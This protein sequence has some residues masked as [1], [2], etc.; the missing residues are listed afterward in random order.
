MSLCTLYVHV[1]I[2]LWSCK[3]LNSLVATL[4]LRLIE[5]PP[6]NCLP[7]PLRRMAAPQPQSLNSSAWHNL[8][9][10]IQLMSTCITPAK[11]LCSVTAW[12]LDYLDLAVVNVRNKFIHLLSGNKIQIINVG[13]VLFRLSPGS[14]LQLVARHVANL[15]LS[16][17]SPVVN[18]HM[19]SMEKRR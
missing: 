7:L 9:Q 3:A 4:H 11:V 17:F 12:L 5:I 13:Y 18:A 2:L 6:E 10:S 16:P 19:H 15:R 8:L 14:G 1:D